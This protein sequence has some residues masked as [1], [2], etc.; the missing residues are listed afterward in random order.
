[1]K[2]I[3]HVWNNL[4]KNPLDFVGDATPLCRQNNLFKQLNEGMIRWLA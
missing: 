4:F 2:N 3:N 1:M